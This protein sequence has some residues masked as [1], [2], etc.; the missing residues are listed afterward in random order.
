MVVTIGLIFYFQCLMWFQQNIELIL[1]ET[2]KFSTLMYKTEPLTGF[3]LSEIK[4]YASDLWSQVVGNSL[5]P[6]D[7]SPEFAGGPPQFQS[8]SF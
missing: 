6:Q 4:S 8:H 1:V 3:E 2:E 5:Y 7:E